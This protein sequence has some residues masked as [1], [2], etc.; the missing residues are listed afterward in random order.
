ML[1][2]V[3]TPDK[4]TNKSN[5]AILKFRKYYGTMY[6]TRPILRITRLQFHEKFLRQFK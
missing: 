6:S 3:V 1:G 2:L 5:R 4:Q